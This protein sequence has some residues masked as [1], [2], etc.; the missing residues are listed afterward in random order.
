VDLVG[1]G[2]GRDLIDPDRGAYLKL[3]FQ[4]TN[5]G[6][7]DADPIHIVPPAPLTAAK[8]AKAAK[9]AKAYAA[10]SGIHLTDI[11]LPAVGGTSAEAT[12]PIS[13]DG[14]TIGTTTNVTPPLDEPNS[15]LKLHS[16]GPSK[17]HDPIEWDSAGTSW[18][19]VWR[20]LNVPDVMDLQVAFLAPESTST[21]RS[22]LKVVGP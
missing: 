12:Q 7:L 1:S 21:S 16:G 5:G 10:S 3:V 6:L 18:R 14:I 2:S 15:F 4:L 11:T 19:I 22:F 20:N 9:G 13:P 8:P 17:P